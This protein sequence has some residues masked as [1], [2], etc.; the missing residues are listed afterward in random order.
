MTIYL[1]KNHRLYG[2]DYVE[3]DFV[4]TREDG[5]PMNSNDMRYF[6]MWCKKEF[7]GGSFHSFRHTHATMML[8]NNIELDYVSKRLG[9]A[10]IATT[11]NIYD[12]I[13][14]K[15]NREAMKKLDSIL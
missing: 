11:A 8:E 2:D 12:T 15:R 13:T 6:N 4:C 1:P 3:S 7:G 14:D 9:H 10:T 5:R